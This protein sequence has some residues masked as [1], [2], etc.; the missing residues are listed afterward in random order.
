MKTIHPAIAEHVLSENEKLR[1]ALQAMLGECDPLNLNC[2]EPW[3]RARAALSQQ[4]E[5]APAQDER[6]AFEAH[7]V[8]HH[9]YQPNTLRSLREGDSYP[10]VSLPLAWS[11]WQARPAQTEQQAT[12]KDCL[13][14]QPMA[15]AVFAANG[16]AVCFSTRRDHPS[17]VALEK[18]GHSV[19]SLAPIAQTE[20]QPVAEV[21]WPDEP[22]RRGG[23]SQ[24]GHYDDPRL[25][26]GAKLYAAPIAQTE[27]QPAQ[28]A[29][30]PEG[31]ALVPITPTEAQWSGLARDL[32]MW[33]DM[34]DKTARGL[35]RHLQM[36]GIEPP[37]WLRDEPEMQ[38][39]GVPSKGTRV[40]LIY[41]AMIEDYRA[42]QGVQHE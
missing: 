25:P 29:V 15:Y 22:G 30:I 7:L 4:A 6:E 14:V 17:L 23:F 27:Q 41:R 3:C 16:N 13:T 31:Y 24:I 21:L 37:Q 9:G 1:A 2:G 19:V 34:S 28:S 10:G 38:G 39:S 40:T 36:L 11:V 20:Q 33:L 26:V 12:V 32:M 18:E 42:A 5:P 35:F 8:A